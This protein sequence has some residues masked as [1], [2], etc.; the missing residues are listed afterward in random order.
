LDH[1]KQLAEEKKAE[2]ILAGLSVQK[3]DNKAA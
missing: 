1:E 2:A 3:G